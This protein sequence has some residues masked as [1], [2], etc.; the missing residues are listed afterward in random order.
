MAFIFNKG[1][2]Q[3]HFYDSLILPTRTAWLNT[4]KRIS[5]ILYTTVLWLCASHYGTRTQTPA[6]S[7]RII[8]LL[9]RRES[10]IYVR[11]CGISHTVSSLNGGWKVCYQV[12]QTD[13]SKWQ[14]N[15]EWKSLTRSTTRISHPEATYPRAWS[16]FSAS[17]VDGLS[18]CH[19]D[20]SRV[21]Y[22]CL[23]TDVLSYG[24]IVRYC[25]LINDIFCDVSDE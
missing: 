14:L 24:C 9:E 25:R 2:L 6:H 11:W 4:C 12:S 22:Y 23:N 18:V 8:I 1:N 13:N 7:A 20:Y 19:V 21:H 5:G 15:R 3:T 17:I 10:W 16:V